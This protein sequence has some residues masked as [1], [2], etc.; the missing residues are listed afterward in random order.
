MYFS[1]NPPRSLLFKLFALLFMLTTPLFAASLSGRITD[2]DGQPL[3]EASI[4]VIDTELLCSVTETF[5]TSEDGNFF[6]FLPFPDGVYYIL[7]QGPG[8]GPLYLGNDLFM[9]I[10]GAQQVELSGNVM[11]DISINTGGAVMG[12]L[13]VSGA[14]PGGGQPNITVLDPVTLLPVTPFNARV[15]LDGNGHYA[16]RGLA[17]GCYLIGVDLNQEG[18]LTDQPSFFYENSF[19]ARDG[20][21][22]EIAA[23][24]T[25]TGVDMNVDTANLGALDVTLNGALEDSDPE[26]IAIGSENRTFR[27]DIQ[28]GSINVLLPPDLYRVGIHYD[29]LFLDLFETNMQNIQAGQTTLLQIT[30]QRGGV[31]AGQVSGATPLGAYFVQAISSTTQAVVGLDVITAQS[32]SFNYE[33]SGLPSGDYFVRVS[34]DNFAFTPSAPEFYDNAPSPSQAQAVSVNAPETTGGIDFTL[35]SGGS[36]QGVLTFNDQPLNSLV[37]TVTAYDVNSGQQFIGIYSSIAGVPF[38]AIE[39]LPPGVYKVGVNIGVAGE[40]GNLAAE[41]LNLVSTPLFGCG[42]AAPSFHPAASTL[43]TGAEVNVAAGQIASDVNIAIQMGGG[44]TGRLQSSDCG[45]SVQT[46]LLGLFQGDAIKRLGLASN[47]V[48][49]LDGLAAGAYTLKLAPSFANIGPDLSVI[50]DE[51]NAF[52]LADLFNGPNA[53]T[54][55]QTI[56]IQTGQ[57]QNIGAWCVAGLNPYGNGSDPN[58]NL[59]LEGENRLLYSWISNNNGNFESILIA[60]NYGDQSARVTMVATR[61]NGQSSRVIARIIPAKGFLEEN[62]SSLFPDLG[63]GGGYTVLLATDAETVR[64]R[65]VTNSLSAPSG[66]SPSQGVAIRIPK[67]EGEA[68]ANTRIGREIMFGYLPVTNGAISAPV[69]VNLDPEPTDVTLRFFDAAGQE[70][71]STT[72]DNLGP[73]TPFARI[74]N[75]LLP[76]G[77]G[78]V[79]MIAESSGGF[80]SGVSF[81]F[82]SVFREPAIGN[83]SAIDRAG[84]DSGAKSLIYP[85][86]SNRSGIFESIVV[87]NNYGDQPVTVTLS[88]SRGNGEALAPIQREIPAHGFLNEFASSL[89]PDFDGAGYSVALEAPSSQVQGQWVTNNLRA[90]SGRSPSQGVAIDVVNDGERRG[91]NL[92]FGYLPVTGSFTSAPVIVNAG[93]G[94]TNV[95]LRF[96]DRSGTMVLRDA[97]SLA[98]LAPGLPF[99]SLANDL[100]PGD[101]SGN[102]YLVATS[103]SEPITGVVFVFNGAF[104]EPAIGNATAIEFSP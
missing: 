57:F 92:L 71:Q 47:G 53:V 15:E 69:V 90:V 35:E 25:V 70:F 6:T 78:D 45:C 103:D 99:A 7:I 39:G 83:V 44:V 40:N 9:D 64:G 94:P 24:Q 42:N 49:E 54:Y 73:N 101:T 31:I 41:F 77:T 43:A 13:T 19:T 63:S 86:I 102:V 17:E 37:A 87:A 50:P 36:I 98:N 75:D 65:W 34:S 22:V 26:L 27:F 88:A 104:N 59:E 93:A 23:A 68:S 60:N 96:Y 81:V 58:G 82:D 67:N 85:W 12:A 48:F 14:I 61:G 30:P 38:Y 8:I 16:V 72:L 95:T 52:S 46:A 91:Q 4:T 66:Q 89:F 79:A 33:V 5:P 97:T 11:L 21:L 32:A 10:G 20:R 62:A 56:N 80:I 51:F 100:L 2:A 76:D 74:V 3:A 84:P 18:D 55:D 28:N 29:T 1:H